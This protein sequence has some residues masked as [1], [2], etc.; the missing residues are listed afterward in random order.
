MN[1]NEYRDQ[2]YL[3]EFLLVNFHMHFLSGTAMSIWYSISFHTYLNMSEWSDVWVL[4]FCLLSQQ[5]NR[6]HSS[7]NPEW[8]NWQLRRIK[9]KKPDLLIQSSK[10]LYHEHVTV[11][12]STVMKKHC[13]S[14]FLQL[15]DGI[16]RHMVALIVAL[17]KVL[18]TLL[19]VGTPD[20]DF[21]WFMGTEDKYLWDSQFTIR[22]IVSVYHNT[23]MESTTIHGKNDFKLI[24]IH[25]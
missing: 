22:E 7:Y 11:R 6:W 24:C 1:N 17:K 9:A 14:F 5:T 3:K 23:G 10:K 25:C 15:W 12:R 2:T 21:C 19:W 4:P 13:H 20:I 18:M 16:S 8:R